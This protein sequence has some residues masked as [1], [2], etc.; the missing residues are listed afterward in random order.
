MIVGRDET[1][2]S[3]IN[4]NDADLYVV[5]KQ[6]N[7]YKYFVSLHTSVLITTGN[8]VGPMGFIQTTVSTVGLFFGA[9][10]NANI[11]GELAVL[12]S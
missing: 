9:V 10:I 3:T 12:V 8:D 11:F 2:I 7:F 1:W 5:Y 6:S 4:Y